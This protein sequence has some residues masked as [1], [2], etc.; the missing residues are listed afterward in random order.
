MDAL[1]VPP[2]QRI[3]KGVAAAPTV[4]VTVDNFNRAES[5]MYFASTIK[6]AGGI[7]KFHHNRKIMD[8]DSQTVI[9]ANRDTLYSAAV[10]DLDAAPVTIVLPDPGRRFMSMIVIDEEQYSLATVYAPGILR[11]TREKIG[12]RYVMI[13]IR[14]FVDPANRKDIDMVHKLQDLII[15]SQEET[16][17]FEATNWDGAGQ[18]SVRELLI[19]LGSTLPDTRGMFG[20]REQVDPVRHLIGTATGWGGNTEKDAMYLTVVPE[21]NDGTTI[22]KLTVTDVPVDGFWSISVYNSAGF[23]EK[24]KLGIYT[25]NNVAAIKNANGSVTIQFG[26]CETKSSNCIPITPG[27]NYWVRLYRPRKEI[28]D[29]KWT[30]P[31]ARPVS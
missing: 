17:S 9:R 20:P 7:G 8:I 26:G 11:Y 28:L 22:H 23:F 10:F 21:K 27:W 24:N 30:F 31:Q 15:A 14:T 4:P 29:R 25:L 2:K 19:A 3:K 6:L 5:E 12:T 1:I 18:K 16:G 13:G